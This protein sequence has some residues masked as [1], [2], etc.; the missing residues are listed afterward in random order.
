M[1]RTDDARVWI[2]AGALG[3]MLLGIALIPLRSLTAASNL[4]FVFLAFTIVVAEFGGRGPALVTA[5]VSAASLNFFLTEPYLTLT[6][7]KTD[8]VVAFIA[9]AGC[10]LIAAAFGRRR[11]RWSER[12]GR[13]SDELDVVKRLV[14]QVRKGAPLGEVLAEMKQSLG[15][16]AVVLREER[17]RVLAAV[18]LD[19]TAATSPPTALDR[20][21]LLPSDESR[22]RFGAR[23]LRLPEGGGRLGLRTRDGSVSLEIWEG[24]ERGL[25]VYETRALVIAASLLE[26]E[27]SRSGAQ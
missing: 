13:A 1:T 8:D 9:L 15:L 11:E 23:G 17:G 24:D 16:A 19:A 2:V 3:S 18:P 22:L 20:D 6:I 12:A 5:L 25:G 4:A 7:T 21:T 14:E 27:L 26:L 10:G